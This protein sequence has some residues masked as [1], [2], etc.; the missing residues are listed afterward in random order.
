MICAC[1]IYFFLFFIFA[2]VWYNKNKN[3]RKI[4]VSIFIALCAVL[5]V[6][7]GE[8]EESPFEYNLRWYKNDFKWWNIW[9]NEFYKNLGKDARRD[10]YN[11]G[12]VVDI[13]N[14]IKRWVLPEKAEL[15]DEYIGFYEML[16]EEVSRGDLKRPEIRSTAA[17]LK[18]KGKEFASKFNYKNMNPEEWINREIMDKS[19]FEKV[20]TAPLITPY[21]KKTGFRYAAHRFGRVF[22]KLSCEIAED[23]KESDRVYFKTKRRALS[24][25]RKPCRECKP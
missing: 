19:S 15:F 12:Q 9:H 20:D 13:I 22:H 5:P 1:G 23:I 24:T 3:M 18:Q 2:G 11:A 17:L 8:D 10:E 21:A 6:F 7:A 25:N 16:K 4:A 14:K